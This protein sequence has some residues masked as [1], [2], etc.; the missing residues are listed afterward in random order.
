MFKQSF[1]SSQ[2]ATNTHKYKDSEEKMNSNKN[3]ISQE[4]YHRPRNQQQQQ[5]N[6]NIKVTPFP[7][8][9]LGNPQHQF[10][11]LNLPPRKVPWSPPPRRHHGGYQQYSRYGL[12]Q[13]FP[14]QSVLL[15]GI[16]FPLRPSDGNVLVN[17]Q[18]MAPPLHRLQYKGLGGNNPNS[19]T[20]RNAPAGF[21]RNQ[22][23]FQP[24]T[25]FL[26]QNRQLQTQR[27]LLPEQHRRVLQNHQPLS[28]YVT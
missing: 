5:G 25:L 23:Q 27:P 6:N 28:R 19:L 4:D 18:L 22:Q 16:F 1:P 14:Q 21:R 13:D 2:F 3:L 15:Q 20:N 10:Q 17:T 26:S 11:N 7:H 24:N 9:S 12:K 8:Q